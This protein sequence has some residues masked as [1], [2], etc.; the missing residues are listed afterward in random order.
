MAFVVCGIFIQRVWRDVLF[1]V[2]A[3][4][5]L[6][7]FVEEVGHGDGQGARNWVVDG[8]MAVGLGVGRSL[9]RS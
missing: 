5:V 4:E 2:F 1:H 6:P 3:E 8:W 9:T 7:R